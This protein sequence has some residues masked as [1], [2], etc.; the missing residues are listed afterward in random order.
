ML[1]IT[2]NTVTEHFSLFNDI[3]PHEPQLHACSSPIPRIRKWSI[4]V[5]FEVDTVN[6]SS[7]FK[8]LTVHTKN[9]KLAFFKFRFRDGELRVQISPAWCQRCT[10]PGSNA[11]LHMS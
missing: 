9:G 4:G 7:V 5:V 10:R 8:M 6:E 1:K 2:Q 11:A 3:P